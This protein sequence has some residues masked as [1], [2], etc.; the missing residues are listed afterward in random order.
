VKI[1]ECIYFSMKMYIYVN[2]IELSELVVNCNLQNIWKGEKVEPVL[3]D[4]PANRKQYLNYGFIV[5]NFN[6]QNMVFDQM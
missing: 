1:E 4:K 3:V 5:V 2:E 6:L